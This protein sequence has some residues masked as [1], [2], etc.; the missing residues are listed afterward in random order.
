VNPTHSSGEAA[1]DA[2]YYERFYSDAQVHDQ[3]RIDG[4][5]NGILGFAT[6]L[7][8]EVK[9][10]LDVGAGMGAV[11]VALN[12]HHPTIRYR[13]TDISKHACKTYGHLNV[14]IATWQP[15]RHYDLTICLSV[16]QYL[17]NR[18]ITEAVNN[19]AGATRSLLYLEIPTTWD[20]DHVI[21]P[22]ATDMNVHWRSGRYYQRLLAPH[23][24][25]VGAGLWIRRTSTVPLFELECL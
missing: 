8:V 25:Q 22:E 4:L 18:Q 17:D 9:S 1:F 3:L 21:N 11:K 7:N 20:R 19:L 23:F 10:V 13:G 6:W 16:L 12:R 15:K 14:D 2:S 24:R 5:V